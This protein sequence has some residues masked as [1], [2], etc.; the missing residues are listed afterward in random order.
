MNK[1]HQILPEKVPTKPLNPSQVRFSCK[2]GEKQKPPRAGGGNQKR[3]QDF[4]Q[5]R[6]SFDATKKGISFFLYI[7]FLF[8]FTNFAFNRHTSKTFLRPVWIGWLIGEERRIQDFIQGRFF[9]DFAPGVGVFV[10]RFYN[11]QKSN[12]RNK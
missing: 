1:N 5:G 2:P 4:I 7:Y 12:I 6:L 9:F 11:L 8:L 3:N 10:S